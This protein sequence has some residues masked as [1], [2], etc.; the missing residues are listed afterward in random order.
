VVVVVVVAVVGFI[1]EKF[2]TMH[3]HMDVKLSKTVEG[4]L[5]ALEDISSILR[6]NLRAVLHCVGAKVVVR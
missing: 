3:G 1:V 4:E 2:V 6:T 5:L